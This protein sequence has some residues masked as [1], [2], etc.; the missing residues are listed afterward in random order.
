MA[1]LEDKIRSIEDKILKILH[2]KK[3]LQEKNLHLEKLMKEKSDRIQDLEQ[4]LESTQQ[5]CQYLKTAN[6][7]LGSSEFKRET[8]FKINSLIKDIDHCINQLSVKK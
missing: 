4:Q 3:E 1:M 2:S 5:E 6:A 7:L 8:K